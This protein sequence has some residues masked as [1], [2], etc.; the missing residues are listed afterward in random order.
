MLLDRQANRGCFVRRS[1]RFFSRPKQGNP[2]ID[3]S[4][5]VLSG[6]DSWRPDTLRYVW[7]EPKNLTITLQTNSQ[8]AA[9]GDQLNV[10]LETIQQIVKERSELGSRRGP[11]G[12]HPDVWKS[13]RSEAH[14]AHLIK[15]TV[16]E[17]ESRR[18]VRLEPIPTGD[19]RACLSPPLAGSQ[20]KNG[21]L[22]MWGRQ[23]WRLP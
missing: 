10:L 6:R 8:P 3:R 17:R 2:W 9:D 16:E 15:N 13:R 23:R 1:P 20:L 4:A 22:D 19:S 12:Y 11:V 14:R 21:L 5:M 18:Q 7:S